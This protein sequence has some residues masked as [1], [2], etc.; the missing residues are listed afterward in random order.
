MST[1]CKCCMLW[2]R[3]LCGGPIS[4][5]EESYWV[6]VCPSAIRVNNNFVHL[7][8]LG[9]RGL[10]EK[11]RK[12]ERRKERKKSQLL[13]YWINGAWW[14]PQK[15]TTC[16]SHCNTLR[17]IQWSCLTVKIGCLTYFRRKP[18]PTSALTFI[19]LK[20]FR[21]SFFWHASLMFQPFD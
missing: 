3:G 10:N 2:D 7:Q 13:C 20:W 1:A 11:E 21:Y 5:P 14:W 16:Q 17:P 15:L 19:I 9:R 18:S 8:L 4:R 6:C 12:K